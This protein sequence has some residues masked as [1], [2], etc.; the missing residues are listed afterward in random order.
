MKTPRKVLVIDDSPDD[1]ELIRLFLSHFYSGALVF[2]QAFDLDTITAALSESWDV[3]LGDYTLPAFPWPQA[4]TLCRALQPDTPFIVVSGTLP[5]DFGLKEFNQPI[6]GYWNKTNLEQ[7]G[8]YVDRI[9]RA[10]SAQTKTDAALDD[11]HDSM[12]KLGADS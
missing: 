8:P 9:I 11:L 4:F 5:A 1:G 3:I 6:D 10:K 7:I 12:G 2:R